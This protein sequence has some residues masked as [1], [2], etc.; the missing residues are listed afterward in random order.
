MRY[1]HV[2]GGGRIFFLNEGLL[3]HLN[4]SKTKKCVIT[5]IVESEPELQR[6]G[7]FML[8]RS[9]FHSNCIITYPLTIST[10]SSIRSIHCFVPSRVSL[11]YMSGSSYGITSGSSCFK[12]YPAIPPRMTQ[13]K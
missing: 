2:T 5:T 10:V 4:T 7:G 11:P 12:T 13:F 8:L 9:F 3:A 6:V 1:C